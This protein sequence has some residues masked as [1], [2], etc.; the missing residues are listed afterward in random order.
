MGREVFTIYFKTSQ[1]MSKLIYTAHLKQ[2]VNQRAVRTLAI[3]VLRQQTY[4][5]LSHLF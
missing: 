2:G 1:V 4:N 3:F 5:V